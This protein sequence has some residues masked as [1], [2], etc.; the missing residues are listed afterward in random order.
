M[1]LTIA[2]ISK[3]CY[4]YGWSGLEGEKTVTLKKDHVKNGILC[5]ESLWQKVI[6]EEFCIFSTPFLTTFVSNIIQLL[7]S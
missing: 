6:I 1:F 5:R 7:T 2:H 4:A 3:L